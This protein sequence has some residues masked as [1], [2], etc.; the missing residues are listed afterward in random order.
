MF[1][2]SKCFTTSSSSGRIGHYQLTMEPPSIV[3][4][5]KRGAASLHIYMGC[6]AFELTDMVLVSGG[7]LKNSRF[8]RKDGNLYSGVFAAE[9]QHVV[10]PAFKVD[11]KVVFGRWSWILQQ[12][13]ARI[14]TAAS[15]IVEARALT[16]GGLLEPSGL[17][18]VLVSAPSRMF[19]R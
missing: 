13:G 6:T 2:D 14:R 15:S 7:I 16:P 18:T 11:G 1:T 8:F 4:S 12:D 3:P 10:L 5:P 19:G 9:Y 17:R